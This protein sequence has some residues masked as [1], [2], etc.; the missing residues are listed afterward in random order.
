MFIYC[1]SSEIRANIVCGTS[2][3]E[4][5]RKILKLEHDAIEWSYGIVAQWERN[6]V[7]FYRNIE[8]NTRTTEECSCNFKTIASNCYTYSLSK[9]SELIKIKQNRLFRC[10]SSG[11][12]LVSWNQID[13]ELVVEKTFTIGRQL[14]FNWFSCDFNQTKYLLWQYSMDLERFRNS[15]SVGSRCLS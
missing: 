10:A 12:Y 7:L 1:I 2:F 11:C 15:L 13:N 8:R 14:K 4:Y 6:C 5:F 9:H 3:D